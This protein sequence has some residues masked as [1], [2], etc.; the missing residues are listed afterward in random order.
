MMWANPAVLQELIER[1][2]RLSAV[3]GGGAASPQVSNELRDTVYTLCVS[4]GTRDIEAALDAART[5]IGVISGPG[6]A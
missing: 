5:R 3:A 6:A 4:T 2:E 1:Y